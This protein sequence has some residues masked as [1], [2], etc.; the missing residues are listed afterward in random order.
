MITLK[1]KKDKE[2]FGRVFFTTTCVTKMS[3]Q[4]LYIHMIQTCRDYPKAELPESWLQESQ[5]PYGIRNTETELLK[6]R[7]F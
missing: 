2:K 5:K 4:D 6:N 1:R 7:L 3:K